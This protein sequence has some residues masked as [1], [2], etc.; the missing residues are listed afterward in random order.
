[1]KM[2]FDGASKHI[3]F[4]ANGDSGSDYIIYKV[5][6]RQVQKLLESGHRHSEIADRYQSRWTGHSVPGRRWPGRRRPLP[7][8]SQTAASI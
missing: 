2:D 7:A 4:M 5:D 1:M 8:R 3:K 6:R